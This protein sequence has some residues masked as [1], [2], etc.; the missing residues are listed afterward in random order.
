MTSPRLARFRSL[1]PGQASWTRMNVNP[2]RPVAATILLLASLIAAAPG[3]AHA[4]A[5][6]SAGTVTWSVEPADGQAATGEA[7]TELTLDAGQSVTEHMLITNRGASDV[8]FR[9]SAADGYFTDTG[10]F[11]MLPADERSVAAGTW[12]TIPDTADVQAGQSVIVPFQVDV[13]ANATPGDHPAGVAASVRTGDDTIG[14]E[15]RVGFRVMT[16]VRGQLA[17]A[18]DITDQTAAYTPS[19]NPFLPGSVT[20]TFTVVNTGNTRLTARPG[21]TS[22]G[23]FGLVAAQSSLAELPEFA[24]GEVRTLTTDMAGVWPTFVTIVRAHATPVSIDGS[25]PLPEVNADTTVTTIPWSH[26]ALLLLLA[27]AASLLLWRDRTRK[28]ALGRMIDHAREEGRRQGAMTGTGLLIALIAATSGGL[29][30]G[31]PTPSSAYERAVYD[32]SAGVPVDVDVTPLPRPSPDSTPTAPAEPTPASTASPAH[33]PSARL[34][35]TG[36]SIDPGLALAA[37]GILLA[38]TAVAWVSARRRPSD[39]RDPRVD[40]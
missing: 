34:A 36:T 13:P 28:K 8:T 10:R 15:S 32:A 35:K 20:V 38:G 22:T 21:V 18:L 26:L 37:S 29:V 25:G 33:S 27:V 17:P 19:V 23:P 14:V 2:L 3:V 31:A 24:P 40:L 9:L 30:L 7:W 5:G 12:I 16:R 6:D 39:I 11:N 4:A 1:E